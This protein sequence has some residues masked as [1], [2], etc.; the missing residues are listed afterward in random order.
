M[1]APAYFLPLADGFRATEHTSGPWDPALQHGG[2][3]A[4]LLA[5]A[6][7]RCETAWP[8]L[9]TRTTVDILG[10]IPV[11]DV[12]VEAG[13]VR[14]GRSVELVTA[15]LSAGGLV[16]AR[17]SGWRL[18]RE[19]TGLA[20]TPAPP[21]PPLPDS[22]AGDLGWECGYLRSVEWRWVA[23][24]FAEPGPATV[25]GRMRV[26]LVPGEQPTGLQRVLVVA[27]SANGVSNV[28]DLHRWHFINADLSVHLLREPHGE[29]ICLQAE[30]HVTGRGFGLAASTLYDSDGAVARGAQ[31][32]RVAA[33]PDRR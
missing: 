13:V 3:A 17:A 14:P 4:A 31:T 8:A 7:D 28:L 18:R 23:G 2:P 19:D 30:T 9:L 20:D 29:W 12:H 33:R 10:P 5:R 11:G 26:P 15:E 25:W 16:V 21:A 32:L 22:P 24:S 27:D 1:T 6:L